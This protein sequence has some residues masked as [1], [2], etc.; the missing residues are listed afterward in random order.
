MTGPLPT[1][2]RAVVL[3]SGGLDSATALACA[4]RDGFEPHALSFRYGQRHARELDC[5]VAQARL[6]GATHRI[7]SLSL[8]DIGGSALTDR[9]VP[10]PTDGRGGGQA[11]PVT[12]VPARNTVFL[13]VALGLA[14]VL[15]ATAIY[16]GVNAVDY[17]GYPDCRPEF[18][19]AFQ[20]VID[21]ATR[22][23]VEGRQIFLVTP[24]IL[25]TKTEIIQLGT[26]LGVNYAHTHSCYAPEGDLACGHCDSC[27]IR[28]QGFRDAG[29]VDPT[30]YS[31]TPHGV[32]KED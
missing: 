3:L 17:S 1:R 20:G 6:Q 13:A 26:K 16:A 27:R 15:E 11:I 32:R 25:L 2:P 19:N 9:S 31:H 29:V 14:E 22:A 10:V 7:V 23:A 18:I 24:L 30:L 5:A 28:H 8:D 12:Y 4:V 21:V